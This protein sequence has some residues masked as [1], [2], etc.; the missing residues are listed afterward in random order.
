MSRVLIS[1]HDPGICAT[2]GEAFCAT[3][4]RRWYG[5]ATHDCGRES[6]HGWDGVNDRFRRVASEGIGDLGAHVG[7]SLSDRERRKYEDAVA[8]ANADAETLEAATQAST[9]PT[10][11][12]SSV[13]R[14]PGPE[15]DPHNAYVTTFEATDADGDTDLADLRVAVKDNMAVAGVPMTC[16]SRA[17]SAAVPSENAAVVDRLL[18]AGATLTGKTN[19]DEMAYGPTSET[20]GFGPVS[21]PHDE[22]RVAGGSSSGSGAV[23]A[24]GDADAALGSDTGGSVRIPAAFCGVVGF[25]P[26]WGAV[27]R[28][29]FVDLAYTLDHI[30]PLA[31]NVEVAARVFDAIAGYDV[32][33]PSSALAGRIGVGETADSLATSPDVGDLTLGVP[34][35]LVADHVSP[36]VREVFE[37]RLDELDE[38]GANFV[39]V[40]IPSLADGV[41]AWN[42]IT[43]TELAA[44]FGQTVTPVERRGPFDV[45]WYDAVIAGVRANEN[46]FGAVLRRNLV[47]GA[48]L[49][50]TYGG[51]HYVRAQTVR[52]R[53]R[54]EF[55]AALADV[56]A[57][58][59]PTMPVVAPEIGA[60]QPLSEGDDENALDVPLA[61]N[62]RPADLAGIPAI[63]VPGGT[64]DGMPVGIQFIGAKNADQQVLQVGHAF[65]QFVAE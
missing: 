2:A 6:T 24:A 54:Q 59:S 57:L 49:L 30:G 19:M 14:H 29:G 37:T 35:Q 25:K 58:V 12:L 39:E 13:V 4:E 18:A 38:A 3:I 60:W 10:F 23:V 62:T 28:T 40:S 32:R 46:Q 36:G 15:R 11:D 47:K 26:T 16:G 17:L 21:N 7:L 55:D 8:D 1:V 41:P 45:D 63:S 65:E 22:T 31:R 56:D 48:H 27:P 53:I 50:H 20:S 64:A 44:A 5:T 51:R 9:R 61:V 43:N 33:D 34:E 42:T 52:D